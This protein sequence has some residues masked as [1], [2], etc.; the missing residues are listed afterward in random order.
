MVRAER[1]HQNQKL[2]MNGWIL[3][4]CFHV[5]ASDNTT[6]ANVAE[7]MHQLTITITSLQRIGSPEQEGFLIEKYKVMIPGETPSVDG[8]LRAAV[9]VNYENVHMLMWSSFWPV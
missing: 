5:Q 1:D 3:G 7:Q 4:I 9:S 6:M 8:P 2:V